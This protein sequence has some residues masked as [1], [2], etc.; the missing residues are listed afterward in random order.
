MN[1]VTQS[2]RFQLGTQING[3]KTKIFTREIFQMRL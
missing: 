3:K 1:T 2:M